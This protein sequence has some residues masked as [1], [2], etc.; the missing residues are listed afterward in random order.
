MHARIGF[1]VSSSPKYTQVP[2]DPQSV[3]A[4]QPAEQYPPAQPSLSWM[5]KPPVPQEASA[6][7]AAPTGV[8]PPED[9]PPDDVVPPDEDDVDVPPPERGPQ[10]LQSDPS[11]Q[12]CVAPSPP[13]SHSPSLAYW[14]VLVHPPAPPDDVVPPDDDVLVP[15]PD[16]QVHAAMSMVSGQMNASRM[17][18]VKSHPTPPVPPLLEPPAGTH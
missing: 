10:S 12:Y 8:A 18:V 3:D 5:Q 11:A 2:V 14:Q 6:A 16:P 9:V 15:P 4:W 7:Q 17:S 1:P 13:S